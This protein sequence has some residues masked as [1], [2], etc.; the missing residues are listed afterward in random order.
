VL[1]VPS[2]GI[3][4]G[5]VGRALRDYGNDVALNA[6]SAIFDHPQGPAAGTHA[7]FEALRV[8]EEGGV[9]KADFVADGPLKTAL[10]KWGGE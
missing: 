3:H 5:I 7:F 8:V 1:P 10:V 6:G 2:A 4:P 9:L